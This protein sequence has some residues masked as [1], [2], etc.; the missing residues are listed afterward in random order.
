MVRYPLAA[1]AAAFSAA[2][3]ALAALPPG[4]GMVAFDRAEARAERVLHVTSSVIPASGELPVDYSAYGRNISP[5]IGWTVGPPGTGSYAVIVE[6]PDAHGATPAVHW[7]AY[8]IPA[9]V[10]Q[11]S[12][13]VRN[14]ATVSSPAGMAQGWNDHGSLGYSGPRPPPGDPPHHY[15][16]QIFAVDRRVRI[17]PGARLDNVLHAIAGHVLAKGRLV[18]TFAAPAPQKPASPQPGARAG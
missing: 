2:A 6:D 18:A 11:L 8:D 7:L 12:K 4:A 13:G 16:F 5:P 1:A 3:P 14:T 10:T 9:D 15:H 17:K